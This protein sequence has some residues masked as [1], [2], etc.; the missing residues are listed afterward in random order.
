MIIRVVLKDPD[1]FSDAISEAV[2]KLRPEGLSN[3]EWSD[4]REDR[5][6]ETKLP[7][8]QYGEYLAVEFDTDKKT[9]TVVEVS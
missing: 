4:I 8:V 5:I 9:A 7:F 1:A 3:R 2:N 6:S